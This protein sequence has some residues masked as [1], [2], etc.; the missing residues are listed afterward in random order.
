MAT[1]KTQTIESKKYKQASTVSEEFIVSEARNGNF[2]KKKYRAGGISATLWSNKFVKDGKE[3][4]YDTV[5]LE[6]VYQDKEGNWQSTNS[7]RLN[8]LPKVNVLMQKVYEDLILKEQELFR[9][10][11]R[12]QEET[13]GG[14]E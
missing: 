12:I 4:H 11:E 9:S 7:L 1:Q 14:K 3:G 6:R 5:S 2:P 13:L 8:D 10:E